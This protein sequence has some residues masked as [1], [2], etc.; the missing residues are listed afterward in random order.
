MQALPP[1]LTDAEIDDMC[2]PLKVGAAKRKRLEKMGMLVKTKPNGRPLVARSEFERVLGAG[3]MATAQ[4]DAVTGPN[5]TALREHIN[6]RKHGAR[7]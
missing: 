6:R 5:V 1:Y 4:N 7:A 3:R 2:A